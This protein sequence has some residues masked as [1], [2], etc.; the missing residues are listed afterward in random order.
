M[1]KV[2]IVSATRTPIGSF[3][4]SLSNISATDLGAESIKNTIQNIF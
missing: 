4:G 2:V 3:L 1:K